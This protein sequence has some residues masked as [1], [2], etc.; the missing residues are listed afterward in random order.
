MKADMMVALSVFWMVVL[1]A[2]LKDSCLAFLKV[3]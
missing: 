1:K 2:V 3:A